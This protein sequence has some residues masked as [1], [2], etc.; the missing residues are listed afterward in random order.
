MMQVGAVERFLERY[1]QE[2]GIPAFRQT[3]GDYPCWMLV[4]ETDN[5]DIPVTLHLM[6]G[7]PRENAMAEG[8]YGKAG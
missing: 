8:L 4:M 2:K 6:D 5:G 3:G 1:F 7:R